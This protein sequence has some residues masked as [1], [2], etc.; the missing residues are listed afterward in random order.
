MDE[1]AQK[2]V[3][4]PLKTDAS[5]PFGHLV[6]RFFGEDKGLKRELEDWELVRGWWAS[7]SEVGVKKEVGEEEEVREEGEKEKLEEGERE[8]LR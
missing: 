8:K 6:V 7:G 1:E 5:V 4:L 3:A 2:I